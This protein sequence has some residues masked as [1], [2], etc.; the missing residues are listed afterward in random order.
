MTLT[1]ARNRRL[2]RSFLISLAIHIGIALVF[3]A[4]IVMN[5]GD[6]PI[7]T[8]SFAKL[9]HIRISTPRPVAHRVQA[10]APVKAPVVKIAPSRV[11]SKAAA[12]GRIA[13]KTGSTSAVPNVGAVIKDGAANA[14]VDATPAVAATA[15]AVTTAEAPSRTTGGNYGFGVEQPVP[16]LDSAVLNQLKSLSIHATIVVTVDENGR[17]KNVAF[18]TTLDPDVEA[19]IRALLAT[20]TWD[21]A[22][23]GGGIGCQAD[24][25]ITL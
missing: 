17:T 18:K 5:A 7:E 4:M 23:C 3:P 2:N 16:I 25:T 11:T 10:V 15:G 1:L 9:I 20:A 14:R 13:A 21:A 19:R 6:S 24:A 12:P 8:I 22:T